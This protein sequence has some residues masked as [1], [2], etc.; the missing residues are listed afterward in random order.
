MSSTPN[1]DLS[2]SIG[3]IRLKNPVIVASGTFGFGQEYEDFLDLNELGAIIPK[4]ISLKPMVGNR[5]PRL[6]ETEGG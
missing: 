4:G 2:T 5:P 3:K 6:F 1:P